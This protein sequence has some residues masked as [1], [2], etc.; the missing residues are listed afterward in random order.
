MVDRP[1]DDGT[2]RLL[3][4]VEGF[5]E[6]ITATSNGSQNLAAHFKEDRDLESLSE[7]SAIDPSV[8]P[9]PG[10]EVVEYCGLLLRDDFNCVEGFL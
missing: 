1:S 7:R 9:P 5:E 8:V 2:G 4:C 10:N 6:L 3:A